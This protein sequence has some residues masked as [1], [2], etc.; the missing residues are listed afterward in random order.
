MKV[1][2]HNKRTILIETKAKITQL[3]LGLELVTLLLTYAF[4][5]LLYCH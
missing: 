3:E 2:K 5:I 1:I 4:Y